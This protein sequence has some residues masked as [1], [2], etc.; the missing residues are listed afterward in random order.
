MAGTDKPP[1]VQAMAKPWRCTQGCSRIRVGDSRAQ[2]MRAGI[3]S[4]GDGIAADPKDAAGVVRGAD[5][6]R[7]EGQWG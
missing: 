6:W 4:V 5:G 3:E 2:D 1:P 7:A